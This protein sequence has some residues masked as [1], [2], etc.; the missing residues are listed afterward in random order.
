MPPAYAGGEKERERK[1][2]ETK[3]AFSDRWRVCLFI[4][5]AERGGNYMLVAVLVRCSSR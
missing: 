1:Q 4:Y 3:K 2:T 5:P